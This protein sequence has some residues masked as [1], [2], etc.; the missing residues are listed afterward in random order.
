MTTWNYSQP[1]NTEDYYGFVYKITNTE[2]GKSYIGRK[3]FW[4]NT[5]KKLT[6]VELGQ[7]A[8]PG[9]K[10]K[11]KIVTTK[12]NW[13]VYWGSNKQ[14][15]SDVKTLG[16]TPFRKQILRLCKTK[17]ELTYW[18][19]AYQCKE[20]VLIGNYYNDNILGKFYRKDFEENKLEVVET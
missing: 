20:D 15:L 12:S 2:S 4:N 3:V 1:F 8:G 13:E 11:T 10:P 19:L 17:K 6:K 5:R 18:E 14:L 9:R 7:Q 16:E